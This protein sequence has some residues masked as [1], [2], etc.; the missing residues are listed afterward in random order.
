MRVE[1][2]IKTAPKPPRPVRGRIPRIAK[3]MALAIKMQGMV[4]RGEVSDYAE[5]AE[6]AMV[7]RARMTQIMN[8]NL[9]SPVLQEQLL[10]LPLVTEGR[11]AITLKEMQVVCLE[12]DWGGSGKYHLCCNLHRRIKIVTLPHWTEGANI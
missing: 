9:L 11:D 7:S 6:L 12:A 5:L 4:D 10:F 2:T 8:L 3:L 1:G